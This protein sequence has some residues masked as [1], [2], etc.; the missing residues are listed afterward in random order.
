MTTKKNTIKLYLSFTKFQIVEEKIEYTKCLFII[1]I[2]IITLK[3][4]YL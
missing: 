2:I 3:S 1:K 4:N